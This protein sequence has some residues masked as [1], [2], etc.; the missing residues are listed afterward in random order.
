MCVGLDGITIH[1][2]TRQVATLVLGVDGEGVGLRRVIEQ[3]P[4]DDRTIRTLHSPRA[5]TLT[6]Y[7]AY[8]VGLPSSSSSTPYMH[9]VAPDKKYIAIIGGVHNPC[10]RQSRRIKL[11]LEKHSDTSIPYIH[12]SF[13]HSMSYNCMYDMWP[14]DWPPPKN[15]KQQ[16]R[17]LNV[18]CVSSGTQ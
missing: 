9:I 17:S 7:D 5:G 4:P 15:L 2:H 18:S 11:P 3:D 8:T 1:I 6:W 10:H 13:T 12:V 16:T 14:S